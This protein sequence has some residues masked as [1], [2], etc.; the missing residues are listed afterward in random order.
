MNRDMEGRVA[1]VTGA[2]EG[3]GLATAKL[4]ARRGAFV[5]I[6]ARNPERLEQ[7][8]A[9]L[10]EIGP[11]EAH[12]LDVSDSDGFTALIEDIAARHGRLDML[13]NN[14]MS[15]NYAAIADLTMKRWRKDFEVNVDA[16]F[17]GTKAAM[18][19]MT[20]QGGGSIVNISSTNGLL[21]AARMSSYSASKAA[22][23]HFTAVAAMEGATLGI[24]VNCV[25]PGMVLTRAT[26]EYMTYSGETAV[27]TVESIPMARGGQPD[28]LAEPIVFLLS[29]AA[30]Y[31][32]GI[33]LPVDGGKSVQL[34]LPS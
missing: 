14:A 2:S 32:T 8:R 29:D 21:A 18:A 22:L 13:V 31:I 16:A 27:R 3:I 24:R 20:R 12:Q 25:V 5:A 1:L 10:A 11:S 19:Q 7:A 23:I 17:V 33:A 4:L 34:Y 30:S 9:E 26:E 28:E 6:C 15:N